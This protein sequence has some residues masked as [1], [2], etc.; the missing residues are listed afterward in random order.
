MEIQSPIAA[1]RS[2]VGFV[3]RELKSLP[4]SADHWSICPPADYY[5]TIN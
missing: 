1:A 5:P 4:D 2:G 3:P